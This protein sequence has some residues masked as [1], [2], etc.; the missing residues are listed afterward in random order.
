[1]CTLELV[2]GFKV[3]NNQED[4]SY[5]TGDQIL[6]GTDHQGNEL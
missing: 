3:V 1:M 6:E 2:P 5:E 4:I